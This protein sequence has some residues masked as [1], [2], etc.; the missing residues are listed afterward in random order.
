MKL[1]GKGLAVAKPA[2]SIVAKA[3]VYMDYANGNTTEGKKVQQHSGIQPAGK[4]NPQLPLSR[5]TLQCG[6]YTLS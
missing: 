5:V 4:T 2:V 6:L 3:V 1:T